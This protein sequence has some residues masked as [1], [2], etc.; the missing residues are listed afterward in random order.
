[1]LKWV[2]FQ[3]QTTC[4]FHLSWRTSCF[5]I[6][7]LSHLLY[8]IVMAGSLPLLMWVTLLFDLYVNLNVWSPTPA[9]VS[10]IPPPPDWNSSTHSWP[11][12]QIKQLGTKLWILGQ[13]NSQA[14]GVSDGYCFSPCYTRLLSKLVIINCELVLKHLLNY[15]DTRPGH[16]S[17][18]HKF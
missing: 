7:V 3:W 14:A 6:K 1:M 18:T 12:I 16:W 5:S 17:H 9:E 13:L 11:P 4:F 8:V 15:V 10:P 2:S